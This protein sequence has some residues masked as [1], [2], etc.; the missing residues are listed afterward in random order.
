MS[1]QVEALFQALGK[2]LGVSQTPEGHCWHCQKPYSEETV[3]TEA[4][5]RET[6]LSGLCEVCFDEMF[7]EEE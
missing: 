7:Q 2:T 4:G 5:W 1:D 6:K 3:F